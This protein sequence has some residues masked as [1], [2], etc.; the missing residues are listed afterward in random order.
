M[1]VLQHAG[2]A[3]RAALPERGRSGVQGREQATA[4]RLGA[5]RQHHAAPRLLSAEAFCQWAGLLGEHFGRLVGGGVFGTEQGVQEYAES[6]LPGA[7]GTS[8][9][10]CPGLV[11]LAE[12]SADIFK[13]RDAPRGWAIRRDRRD[14][15]AV[16]LPRWSSACSTSLP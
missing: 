11:V 7:V 9:T 8:Q 16:A 10:P 3:P 13:Q 15:T 1:D 14:G 4:Q 2:F 6:G 5:S 12:G